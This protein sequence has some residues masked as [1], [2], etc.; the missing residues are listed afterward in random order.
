MNS[1]NVTIGQDKKQY[2]LMFIT[3]KYAIDFGMEKLLELN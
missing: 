3:I 1:F 2:L